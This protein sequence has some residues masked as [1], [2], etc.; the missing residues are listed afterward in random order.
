MHVHDVL[1]GFFHKLYENTNIGIRGFTMWKKIQWQNIIP[2]GDRTQA[3]H[4]LWFQVQCSSFWASEACANET[5]KLL[6][7]HH[8]ILGL[9]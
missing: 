2:S 7:M 4:N 9:G 6:F 1:V 3:S 8:L 5:F